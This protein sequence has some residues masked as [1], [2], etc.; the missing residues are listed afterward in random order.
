MQPCIGKEVVGR[1]WVAAEHACHSA[2]ALTGSGRDP[3]DELFVLN[4][5][6]DYVRPFPCKLLSDIDH[7]GEMPTKVLDDQGAINPHLCA[8]ICRPDTEKNALT[9][10][11]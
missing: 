9:S 4:G 1:Q 2:A 10:P 5:D 3:I 6:C 8:V 7:E 11:A